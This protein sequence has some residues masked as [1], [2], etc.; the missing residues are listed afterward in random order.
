MQA[1]HP[2][3]YTDQIKIPKGTMYL[4]ENVAVPSAVAEMAKIAEVDR[5][6]ANAAAEEL[7]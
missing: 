3:L 5:E 2:F 4:Y 7:V 1:T 6:L